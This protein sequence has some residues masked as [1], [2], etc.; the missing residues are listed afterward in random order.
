MSWFTRERLEALAK[1]ASES[2]HE[3]PD[4]M[5]MGPRKRAEDMATKT[6]G[7]AAVERQVAE[8]AV[9]SREVKEKTAQIEQLKVGIRAYALKVSLDRPAEKRMEQVEIES[10]EGI[11]TVSFVKDE[12]RLAEG[13][14]PNTLR[15]VISQSTWEHLFEER[16]V[17]AANFDSKFKLL[18]KAD[19][20]HVRGLLETKTPEPRV[21]LPK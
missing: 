6:V 5:G 7:Q 21:L 9:L 16:V 18:S 4:N 3:L 8:A 13:A 11:A 10:R 2:K 19:Q 1:M 12:I 20:N 15:E 17:L 14:N